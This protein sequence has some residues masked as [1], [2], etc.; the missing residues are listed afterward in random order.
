MTMSADRPS[1]IVR[2]RLLE[3]GAA[4][5]LTAALGDVSGA[6]ARALASDQDRSPAGASEPPGLKPH[7]VIYD[8][9]FEPARRFAVSVRSVPVPVHPIRGDV[10]QL[11]YSVLCPLWK[12]S[13]AP[14]AGLTA[15]AAMF[16]L[17]RLAWDHQLRMVRCAAGDA[18]YGS[19]GWPM[20]RAAVI[21]RGIGA[22]S[23]AA[24]RV[25]A[26]DALAAAGAAPL[27]F[28]LIASPAQLASLGA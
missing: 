8:E 17:E 3:L 4:A 5:S 25:A 13:P 6:A 11:W 2:R 14:L 20:E 23:L 27:H 15:Y 22:S 19:A 9:R 21:A 12:R 24:R 10:T 18:V 7:A 28:W 1:S 26:A 16:C